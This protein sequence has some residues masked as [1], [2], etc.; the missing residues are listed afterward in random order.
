MCAAHRC[1][2][3]SA[4]LGCGVMFRGR[5]FSTEHAQSAPGAAVLS[6]SSE[7]DELRAQ[8]RPGDTIGSC[9][10]FFGFGGVVFEEWG[11]VVVGGGGCRLVTAI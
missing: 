2:F 1:V 11:C 4:F 9:S 10:P 3:I 5:A 8:E 7:G 6:A